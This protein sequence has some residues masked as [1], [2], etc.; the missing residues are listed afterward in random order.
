MHMIIGI[1]IL[2]YLYVFYCTPGF[3][4]L[5]AVPGN[6]LPSGETDSNILVP[7]LC[8]QKVDSIRM[9]F[10]STRPPLYQN[11]KVTQYYTRMCFF[12]SGTAQISKLSYLSISLQSASA[13]SRT[14]HKAI[15]GKANGIEGTCP[16]IFDAPMLE[17]STKSQ[18]D[19][20]FITAIASSCRYT[21]HF[22]NLCDN[23][24]HR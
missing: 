11:T 10:W 20:W 22:H 16:S 8:Q 5:P 9:R 18:S 1:A 17:S 24:I 7:F 12:I 2:F 13:S 21:V 6:S 3:I 4:F 23:I 19:I 14:T 15:I